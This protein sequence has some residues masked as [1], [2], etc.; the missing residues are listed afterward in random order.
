[1]IEKMDKRDRAGLFRARLAEAMEARQMSQTALAKAVGV[2]RSTISQLLRA[3]GPRLPNAQLVAECAAA[4]GISADWLLGLTDRPEAAA[5]LVAAAL[6]ITQAPRALVDEQIF[7]WHQEAKGYKIRHVPAG[8]PDMLKTD[9]AL[10]WEYLPT[11][12][13]SA[14]QAIGASRDRLT[15]MREG[16]SDFEIAIRLDELASF[17]TGTGYY[18]GL[19][20]KDRRAQ[21]ERLLALHDQ[22]YPTLRL[23]LFDARRLFSAPITVFGPLLGVI[24]LGQNYLA[25]RDRDRVSLLTRHFDVLVREADVTP[26]DLPGHLEALLGRI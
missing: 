4:L 5:E 12:G 15:W 13:K 11:L 16:H 18:A 7:A 1:M 25:F 6:E 26:R 24:Y 2:Q 9:A 19:P 21:L 14:E 23:H 8:L 20:A 3:D 17:A 10:E 22:L